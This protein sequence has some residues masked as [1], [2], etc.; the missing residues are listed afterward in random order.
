MDIESLIDEHIARQAARISQVNEHLIQYIDCSH[1]LDDFALNIKHLLILDELLTSTPFLRHNG[2]DDRPFG[3]IARGMGRLF[4]GDGKMLGEVRAERLCFDDGYGLPL[5]RLE[6]DRL[7]VSLD[8]FL[9]MGRPLTVSTRWRDS[10]ER[11]WSLEGNWASSQ[12]DEWCE[13]VLARYRD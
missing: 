13:K 11:G 2:S 12:M 1:A 7:V 6:Y 4:T 9:Q 3:D 10:C 8:E 5:S